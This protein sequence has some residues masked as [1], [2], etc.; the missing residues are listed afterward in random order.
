MKFKKFIKETTTTSDI[1][2]YDTLIG[3]KGNA[4]T[5]FIELILKNEKFMETINKIA[6][7]N[8]LSVKRKGDLVTLEG[9]TEVINKVEMQLMSLGVS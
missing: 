3:D 9:P 8:N 1:E 5:D 6:E 7:K 2:D 4:K